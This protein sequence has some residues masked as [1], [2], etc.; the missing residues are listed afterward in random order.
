MEPGGLLLFNEFGD[1]FVLH[2]L[3]IQGS[4]LPPGK[5]GPGLFQT[6]RPQETPYNIRTKWCS[7]SHQ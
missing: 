3:Q 4:D 6:V 2:L 5:P 1:F 7:Q